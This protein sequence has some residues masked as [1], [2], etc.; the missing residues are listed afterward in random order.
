[1]C[2]FLFIFVF[3]RNLMESSGH[4]WIRWTIQSYQTL[5][6][7]IEAYLVYS[8]LW[9]SYIWQCNSNF[10]L[11]SHRLFHPIIITTELWAIYCHWRR[12]WSDGFLLLRI[13]FRV[14]TCR[15]NIYLQFVFILYIQ[16]INENM[17]CGHHNSDRSLKSQH[18]RVS[19]NIN[20]QKNQW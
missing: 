7:Q 12:Y 17:P 3:W 6:I 15:T 11:L 8:C 4:T 9:C 19:W 1:M 14:R 13:Q 16:L 2:S 20:C 18:V 5:I 10:C